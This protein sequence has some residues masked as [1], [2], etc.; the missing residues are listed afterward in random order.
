MFGGY[1]NSFFVSDL[2]PVLNVFVVIEYREG[3]NGGWGQGSRR[4]IRGEKREKK[5]W[6][7]EEEKL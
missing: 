1:I 3:H 2:H 4:L 5:G 7:A 6:E